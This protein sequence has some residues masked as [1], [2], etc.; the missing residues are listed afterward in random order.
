M[1]E[2]YSFAVKGLCPRPGNAETMNVGIV[3]Q[4]DNDRAIQLAARLCD[5]LAEAG[6]DVVFDETTAAALADRWDDG[7]DSAPVAALADSDLVVSIGGDGTFL[8]AARAAGTTPI[9][10]V[11]LGEVGFLNAVSPDDAEEVVIAAVERARESGAPRTRAMPRLA[12][13]GPDWDL[14]PAINDVVVQGSRRG[15]GGGARFDVTIDGNAYHVGAADGVLVSTPTGSTAYN[16]SEG[17]PLV[18]PDVAGIVVNP[19]AGSDAMPPLVVDVESE[20]VVRVTDAPAAVAVSDGRVT[21]PLEPP[22]RVTVARA[23]QPVRVAGPPLDFF[24]ALDKLD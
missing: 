22:A 23:D 19:M 20:I 15:H 14:A 4:K 6:A 8:Y 7:P 1:G 12:A 9:M 24:T 16:L 10:G 21:E 11:N 2:G 13:S 17:G 3:G 18:H 5:R